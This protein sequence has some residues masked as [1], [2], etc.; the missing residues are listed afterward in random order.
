[1]RM[2][3]RYVPSLIAKH[4]YRLFSGR[5]HIDGR[6]DFDFHQGMVQAQSD[7]NIEHYRTVKEINAEIRKLKEMY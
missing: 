6:G 5:I 4:V 7:G 3:N 1:M 2:F